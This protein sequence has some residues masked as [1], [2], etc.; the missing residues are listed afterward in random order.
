MNFQAFSAV[1]V[2]E[3]QLHIDACRNFEL[4]VSFVRVFFL[5]WF[6]QP[7]TAS[8]H[9]FAFHNVKVTTA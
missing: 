2:I 7:P 8:D 1:F 5:E 4:T 3:I 6:A 9:I